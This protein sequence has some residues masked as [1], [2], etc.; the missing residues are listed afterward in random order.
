MLNLEELPLSGCFLTINSKSITLKY[1]P[2]WYYVTIYLDDNTT[3]CLFCFLWPDDKE[4]A[5]GHI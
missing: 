2:Q 4:H 3:M 1:V 5:D